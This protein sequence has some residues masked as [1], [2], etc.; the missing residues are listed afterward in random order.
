M[1]S[2]QANITETTLRYTRGEHAQPSRRRVSMKFSLSE[3]ESYYS[4]PHSSPSPTANPLER[5]KRLGT[6]WFGV[7]CEIE[8]VLTKD[9]HEL[10]MSAWR[11]VAVEENLA[12]P[13]EYDMKRFV[14]VKT[15]QL[16]SQIFR[17][18]NDKDEIRRLLSRKQQLLLTSLQ[19]EPRTLI[20]R[21][22]TSFLSHLSTMDIPFVL[23]SQE[24]LTDVQQMLA[25]ISL[26]KDI[27]E[28]PL[29]KNIN[30][31]LNIITAEDFCYGLP[32]SECLIRASDLLERPFERVAVIASSLHALEAAQELNMRTVMVAGRH[33]VWELKGADLVVHGLDEISFQNMKNMF[34]DV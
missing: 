33:R 7:V 16:V 30:T 34:H 28:V 21:E 13:T 18:T 8:G 11:Q 23:L 5:W 29:D 19:R 31:S 32:D 9:L 3:S 24:R 2:L 15:E 17:W 6:S 4:L 12:Q 22:T 25:Y 20:R 27:L 1:W 10:H 26:E 14:N